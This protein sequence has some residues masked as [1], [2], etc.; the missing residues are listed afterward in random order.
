MRFLSRFCIVIFWLALI[1][2]N[3]ERAVVKLWP[4]PFQIETPLFVVIMT[5][6]ILTVVSAVLINIG[7]KKKQ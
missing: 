2:S 5:V 6:G 7:E 4:L 3:T 1:L